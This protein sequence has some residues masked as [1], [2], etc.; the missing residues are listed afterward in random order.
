M[1]HLRIGALLSIILSTG[2]V[3][4]LAAAEQFANKVAPILRQ[5]CVTCHNPTKARGGLDLTTGEGLQKGGE[6]GPVVVSGNPAKSPLFEVVNGPKP[7]MPKQGPKL[8]ADD[9]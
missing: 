6:K 8:T 5:R 4:A 3:G 7:R 9:V 1:R 2:S